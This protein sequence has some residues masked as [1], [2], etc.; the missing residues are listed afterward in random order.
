MTEL[1][2][3]HADTINELEK[4]RNMLIIQ[5]KINKDYQTEVKEEK[6]RLNRDQTAYSSC[7]CPVSKNYSRLYTPCYAI[8]IY[9]K[10]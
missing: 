3:S 2:A 9:P 1:Q 8:Y 4:T 5:H 6:Y 7:D 10:V